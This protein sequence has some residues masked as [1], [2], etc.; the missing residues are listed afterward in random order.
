MEKE[1]AATSPMD[2]QSIASTELAFSPFVNEQ[3]N[4]IELSSL[5]WKTNTLTIVLYLQVIFSCFV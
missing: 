3:V 2:F 4:R 1:V 5:V